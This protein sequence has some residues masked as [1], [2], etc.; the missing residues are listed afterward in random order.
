MKTRIP[1]FVRGLAG[2]IVGGLVAAVSAGFALV[3][4]YPIPDDKPGVPNYGPMALT[5][6]AMAAF[7][8]GGFIGRR[9]F[10]SGFSWRPI[11]IAY[12]CMTLL[13]LTSDASFQEGASLIGFVS[14][15][16]LVS[17]VFSFTAMR[18][19]P[20]KGLNDAA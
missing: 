18:W 17:I 3:S 4:V 14:V 13:C 16:I 7:L 2:F 20:P 10:T 11:V 5:V 1:S 19:L 15:G 12:S 8:S 6:V 9:G